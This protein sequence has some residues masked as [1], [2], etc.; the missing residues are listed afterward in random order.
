MYNVLHIVQ[1]Y[2]VVAE[3][4]SQHFAFILC[5]R[6]SLDNPYGTIIS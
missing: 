3:P 2:G 4:V 1:T 5:I 6:L